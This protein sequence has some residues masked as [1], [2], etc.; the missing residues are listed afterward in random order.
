MITTAYLL[1]PRSLKRG[2][3]C[4]DKSQCFLKYFVS[5]HTKVAPVTS[6]PSGEKA[7]D[8]LVLVSLMTCVMPLSGPS[9]GQGLAF[10]LLQ[11]G[12][13]CTTWHRTARA[14]L[15]VRHR[16]YWL[17][18]MNLRCIS[19]CPKTKEVTGAVMCLDK[20]TFEG[21]GAISRQRH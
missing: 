2:T 7:A 1:W 9:S 5:T 17:N 4:C 20:E 16:C 6:A 14:A 12:D 15:G 13:T 11:S 10:E 3:P 8:M 19:N 18:V 21:A